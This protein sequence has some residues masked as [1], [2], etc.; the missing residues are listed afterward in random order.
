[1]PFVNEETHKICEIK[2]QLGS[3]IQL[4]KNGLTV[5]YK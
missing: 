5:V 2:D 1:M 4:Y 3:L